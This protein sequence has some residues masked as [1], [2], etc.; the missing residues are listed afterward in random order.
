MEKFRVKYFNVVPAG[1]DG[2]G[3]EMLRTF[4]SRVLSSDFFQKVGET[5]ATK[6]SLIAIG[7]VTSVI[8]ARILGPEGRGLY[9]VAVAIG[10][11]GVQFSNLGLHAA[12]TYYVARDRKLL[13]EL[14][15]NT[16]MV[17]FG[18]GG[19]IT[20]LMWMIFYLWPNLAPVHGLLLIL[21]L[22]WI[23]FGIAYML[24]QNLLLGIQEVRDYNKIETVTK[25]FGVVLIGLVI[26]VR[27]VTVETVFSAGLVALTS[28]FVWSLWRLLTHMTHFPMPSF[29]L[30][31]DNARY[32][33]K[34][35]LTAF[36]GFLVL[37]A[38]V[39]MV[40]YLLGAEQTGYYSVAASMSEMTYILPVTVGALL[41]PKLSALSGLEEKKYLTKRVS[42]AIGAGMFFVLVITAFLA[43]PFVKLLYGEAFLQSVSAFLWLLPGMFFLGVETVAVQFLNSVGFPRIVVVAWVLTCVLNISL[44]MWAIPKYGIAGASIVSSLSYFAVFAVVMWVSWNTRVD[45]E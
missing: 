13:P 41:F 34:A 16:L 21:S 22:M 38:D 31:K 20:V 3:E 37:R 39:L 40:K 10:A 14:T 43:K 7:L 24:L 45:Y 23:P 5:F 35:Y 28:S 9:G 36:F 6:V 17:S 1:L 2:F 32:G 19:F 26:S 44:N 33:L 27:R 15:S 18:F 8:I 25:I 42:K 29:A 30:L 12:N 11:I 4:Y